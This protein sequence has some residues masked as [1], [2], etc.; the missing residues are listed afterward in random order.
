M[1]RVD[2]DFVNATQL[3]ALTSLTREERAAELH[4]P[5]RILIRGGAPHLQGAWVPLEDARDLAARHDLADRAWPILFDPDDPPTE[6]IIASETS[7]NENDE[8]QVQHTDAAVVTRPQAKAA[9]KQDET[10][11][12][13]DQE[14]QSEEEEQQE[15]ANEDDGNEQQEPWED[16]QDSGTLDDLVASAQD[17]V[18]TGV[19]SCLRRLQPAPSLPEL[20]KFM[21]AC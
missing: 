7:L 2:N 1:R 18:R 10:P 6:D 3:L 9:K 14:G 4:I 11:G 17:A 16:D 19:Q 21:N 15:E 5:S 13:T 8:A 20:L 12:R